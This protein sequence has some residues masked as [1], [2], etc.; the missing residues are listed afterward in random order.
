M[1]DTIAQM[2]VAFPSTLTDPHKDRLLQHVADAM[3]AVLKG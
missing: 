1:F 3:A 2:V